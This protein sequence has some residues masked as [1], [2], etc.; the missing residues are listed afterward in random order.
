VD[1][2]VLGLVLTQTGSRAR[3]LS[4]L[5]VIGLFLASLSIYLLTA[6]GRDFSTDGAQTFF[7]ARSLLSG[8]ISIDEIG[9]AINARQSSDGHYYNKGGPLQSIAELPFL[10]ALRPLATIIDGEKAQAAMMR[11]WA[12]ILTSATLS[13][14]TVAVSYLLVVQLGYSALTALIVSL[15]IGFTTPLWVYAKLDLSEP[16]QCLLILLAFYKLEQTKPTSSIRTDLSTGIAL[17]LLILVKA[18]FI[19]F[20][21]VFWLALLWK[22]RCTKIR[23]IFYVSLAFGLPIFVVGLAFLAWNY[24]R[25]GTAFDFGYKEPFDTPL[26]VGL[27]GLF[28]SSGKSVFLYAPLLVL[29]IG[30]L[31]LFV[32]RH[33]F[34]FVVISSVT[35]PVACIYACFWAWHGDWAWGPRYLIPL[36]PL[37]LLPIATVV[38][39]RRRMWHAAV[40]A[41]A[42]LGLFI[43]ILGITINPGNYLSIHTFQITPTVHPGQ[44][45]DMN[46]SQLDVHFIPDF[47]P[48]AGHWWLLKA[49]IESMITH[50]PPDQN[51]ALQ[52]YPWSGRPE[53]LSWRPEHPEYGSLLD[54][55]L[56]E[57]PNYMNEEAIIALGSS[58]VLA[59]IIGL[60]LIGA[61]IKNRGVSCPAHVELVG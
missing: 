54:F 11:A 10:I 30:A 26:L 47:S 55:W 36:I 27:Y 29:A 7:T 37:W 35:V 61:G 21:P 33:R 13:A 8:K 49:T 16:L 58:L 5:T 1:E 57:H 45:K 4:K 6:N 9:P 44:G 43:Q 32:R 19:V 15:L 50:A 17:S 39:A 25:W 53:R 41:F 3:P 52:A 34:E 46:Q 2:K 56:V 28:L 20:A 40:G 14:A 59:G 12:P 23:E 60:L 38:S 18:I 51:H 48:L 24:A 42:M 22:R 31:P